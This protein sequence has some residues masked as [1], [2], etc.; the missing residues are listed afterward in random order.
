MMIN[1]TNETYLPPPPTLLAL[2]HRKTNADA[3]ASGLGRW[4]HVDLFR[5]PEGWIWTRLAGQGAT[6]A[7]WLWVAS[8]RCE[9]A[10]VCGGRARRWFGKRGRDV[11]P[12]QE[13]RET[14]DG[15]VGEESERASHVGGS[16]A[17][18]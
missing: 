1:N 15:V 3:I 8:L 4:S 11:G 13:E 14:E 18:E 2:T 10:C 9:I 16:R 12:D 6:R 17:G 7:F 5:L